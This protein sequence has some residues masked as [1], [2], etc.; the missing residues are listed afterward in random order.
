MRFL[1]KPKPGAE[2]VR[3][4]TETWLSGWEGHFAKVWP[5]IVDRCDDP[6]TRANVAR[7]IGTIIVRHPKSRDFVREL[8]ALYQEAAEGKPGNAQVT[9]LHKTGEHTL[10]VS[11]IQEFAL[12][13]PDSVRTDFIRL[14][15]YVSKVAANALM[16]RR[17]M[18]FTA[19]DPC[20]VTSDSPVVTLKGSCWRP[21]YGLGTPGTL[22]NFPVSPSRFLVLA[23]EWERTFDHAEV[24]DGGVFVERIVSHADRFVFAAT[25]SES[26]AAAIAKR[27]RS[28]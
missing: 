11:E 21:K 22:V 4:D 27:N 26:I 17:W 18:V 6:R 15:P 7:F 5:D 16:S 10:L 1:Y 25:P 8:N 13:D 2:A 14:M 3:G 9:F 20:F 28:N 12:T 24:E 23:D 19:R